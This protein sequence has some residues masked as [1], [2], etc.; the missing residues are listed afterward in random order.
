MTTELRDPDALRNARQDLASAKQPEEAVQIHLDKAEHMLRLALLALAKIEPVV[1]AKDEP[2]KVTRA[3]TQ[4]VTSAL[5]SLTD[6]GYS[7]GEFTAFV[8]NAGDH[9]EEV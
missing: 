5:E 4:A 9:L 1:A 2:A 7:F 3:A 6:A 8:T